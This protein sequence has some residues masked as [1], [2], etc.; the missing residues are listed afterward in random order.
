[1]FTWINGL[2][3]KSSR[4]ANNQFMAYTYKLIL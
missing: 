1:M 3:T 2:L 4:T